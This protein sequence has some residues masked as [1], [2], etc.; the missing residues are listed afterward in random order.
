MIV[1]RHF[2]SKSRGENI[3]VSESFGTCE[4]CMATGEPR[5]KFGDQRWE[6]IPK[7]NSAKAFRLENV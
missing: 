5:I 7:H 2:P 3:F 4:L 6:E 1:C